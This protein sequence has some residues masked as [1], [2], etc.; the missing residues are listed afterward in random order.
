VKDLA[1]KYIHYSEE[2]FIRIHSDEFR[3][4]PGFRDLIYKGEKVF[5]FTPTQGL[6]IGFI[7]K[8]FEEG[9]VGVPQNEVLLY[10]QGHKDKLLE[11]A[12][13]ST[14]TKQFK[15]NRETRLRSFFRQSKVSHPAWG[16]F[17]KSTSNHR[18][19]LD[20]DWKPENS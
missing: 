2:G 15:I 8:Y 1:M 17:I 19:F 6:I 10:L 20:F 16:T 4:S 14:V 3:F 5:E 11:N 18:L 13:P 7:F 9:I 12:S